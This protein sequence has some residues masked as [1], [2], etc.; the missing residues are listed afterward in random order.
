MG[1]RTDKLPVLVWIH[2]GGWITGHGGISDAGPDYLLEHDVVLVTGN[3]R[4]GPLGF[5]STED[6]ECS[7][8]FGLKD[9]AAMLKWVRMN[10]DKFGGDSRSVTIFGNS[11]GREIFA[12]AGEEQTEKFI[13][14]RSL[15]KLPHDISDVEGAV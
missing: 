4:L 8:N 2:G 15:S 6:K 3:Y 11:A 14:R 10:I 9:Q 12:N 7:G 5:L 13:F 1:N